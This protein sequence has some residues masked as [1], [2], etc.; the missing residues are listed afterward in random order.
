MNGQA[1]ANCRETKERKTSTRNKGAIEAKA[2][3]VRRQRNL[4]RTALFTKQQ[5]AG[6]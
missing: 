6:S 4:Q 1:A 2:K 3:T 5:Q